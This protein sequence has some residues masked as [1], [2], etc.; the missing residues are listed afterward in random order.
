MLGQMALKVI[1]GML[2]E[3]LIKA[4]VLGFLRTLVKSTKN[5]I[6][7]KL[8]EAVQNAMSEGK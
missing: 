2:T 5:T 4:I 7:D 8:V 3:K 1:T 6:D